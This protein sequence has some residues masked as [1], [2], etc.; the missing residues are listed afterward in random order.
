MNESDSST[1]RTES[2]CGPREPKSRALGRRG[3]GFKIRDTQRDVMDTFPPMIEESRETAA[4]GKRLHQLHV[5]LPHR[6][7]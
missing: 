3:G 6:K 4:S 5:R 1:I 2:G 7:K